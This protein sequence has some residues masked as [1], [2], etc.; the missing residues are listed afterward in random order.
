MLERERKDPDAFSS[1]SVGRVV[2]QQ[3]LSERKE[4]S[5]QDILKKENRLK[6]EKPQIAQDEEVEEE[7]KGLKIKLPKPHIRLQDISAGGGM[8]Y[9]TSL[10]GTE[11]EAKALGGTAHISLRFTDQLALET[12]LVLAPLNSGIEGEDLSTNTDGLDLPG[13]SMAQSLGEVSEISIS[14]QSLEVPLILKY[15]FSDQPAASW[16]ASAGV[17]GSTFLNQDIS[18]EILEDDESS[19]QLTEEVEE[20]P[21][22]V[23]SF[24]LGAG[25]NFL[26]SEKTALSLELIYQQDFQNRGVMNSQYNLLGINSSIWFS[27][28]K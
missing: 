8:I 19:L 23:T 20:S 13:L 3:F 15:Y 21:W 7:K 10:G 18:Y 5:T 2:D 27:F 6:E 4:E 11:E 25:R 24:R 17:V 28:K 12:G 22:G 16:F 14:G 1:D 26:L 9:R